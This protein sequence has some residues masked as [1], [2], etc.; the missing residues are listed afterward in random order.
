MNKHWA[1]HTT[2]HPPT[3]LMN[4]FGAYKGEIVDQ[5]DK[6]EN[7]FMNKIYD[8]FGGIENISFLDLRLAEQYIMM[9]I[10]CNISETV[11]RKAMKLSK[12]RRNYP[13]WIPDYQI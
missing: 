13:S 12:E 6:L 9:G 5:I 8:L 1:D 3:K 7:E 4:D 10:G 2:Q 11:L